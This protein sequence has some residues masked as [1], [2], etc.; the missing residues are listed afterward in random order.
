[1]PR[2]SVWLR[3]ASPECKTLLADTLTKDTQA[4]LLQINL[5]NAGTSS[6]TKTNDPVP[7]FVPPPHHLSLAA[8]LLVH[9]SVT[10]LASSR[11][12]LSVSTAALR[13]LR[14]VI[15][16]VGPRNAHLAE[17][18]TFKDEFRRSRRTGRS[19]HARRYGEVSPERNPA[20]VEAI[21]SEM[22]MAGSLWALAEDFWHV[23]G[24]ALNCSRAHPRRWLR[25]KV[26]LE[27]MLEALEADGIS[28][29]SHD[30]LNS[31]DE[32]TLFKLYLDQTNV[33]RILRAIFA[34][35]EK[36]SLNEFTCIFRD[37]L[38][39]RRKSVDATTS[40]NKRKRNN[41][42]NIE[43]D[44]YG[45]YLVDEEENYE[46]MDS[47]ADGKPA[48]NITSNTTPSRATR[49]NE[50]KTPRALTLN[51]T[52][53]SGKKP[54][55]PFLRTPGFAHDGNGS[56][57]DIDMLS[58]KPSIKH[59]AK[60]S[61]QQGTGA[62]IT[63][64][65]TAV[66]GSMESDIP[67][68][69]DGSSNLGGPSAIALRVRLITLLLAYSN[70]NPSALPSLLN[71]LVSHIR[72]LPLATF[73][74][75]VLPTSQSMSLST[76]ST[77]NAQQPNYCPYGN[78]AT[79]C[80]LILSLLQSLQSSNAPP[81][82]PAAFKF[83]RITPRL[84]ATHIAPFAANTT[85]PADNAKVGTCVEAL[86]RAI[87]WGKQPKESSPTD[88]EW[89]KKLFPEEDLELLRQALESGIKARE[90]KAL[91]FNGLGGIS[92]TDMAYL[93]AGALRIE[94]AWVEFFDFN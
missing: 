12:R 23:V 6:K 63:P 47:V 62:A 69:S 56:D 84:V 93:K 19:N 17:A 18:F 33:R 53:S 83:S 4:L 89:R 30:A 58:P 25:W 45:D 40:I 21:N 61:K 73:N 24:W 7:A 22:A 77:Q 26:W 42:V 44:N 1:M 14:S 86:I 38:K 65:S 2:S 82:P 76:A 72:P 80:Q 13:L 27:L 46:L 29:D 68:P 3:K 90:E 49:A 71:Y 36:S 9:P 37:E 74:L 20:D 60:K 34:D 66:L 57:M 32:P 55:S 16:L 41:P 31:E 54:D 81:L 92:T 88:T 70:I 52:H 87:F 8:T 78:Y 79:Y 94:S 59:G 48:G 28:P 10:T 75:F 91:S 15:K 39:E 85:R 11:E 51:L 67:A 35:G 5:L 43:Q 50:R 64:K